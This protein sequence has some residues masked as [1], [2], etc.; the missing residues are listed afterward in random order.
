[1]SI[2]NAAIGDQQLH[3]G[4]R[5]NSLALHLHSQAFD[6]VVGC[7]HNLQVVLSLCAGIMVE[8]PVEMEMGGF[9]VEVTVM[10]QG[11]NQ[12][13]VCVDPMK[14]EVLWGGVGTP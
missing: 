14:M 9:V 4:I 13:R 3:A 7:V 12:R 11:V 1:M 6:G 10:E 2:T 8:V 5:Q